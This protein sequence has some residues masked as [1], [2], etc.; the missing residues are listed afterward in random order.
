MEIPENATALERIMCYVED[1]LY[2]KAEAL[3]QVCD[4]LEE[5]Y[6]WEISL[7]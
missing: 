1:G 3:S 2:E 6:R 4:H 5:C 7:S